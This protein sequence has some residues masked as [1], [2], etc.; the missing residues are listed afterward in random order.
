MRCRVFPAL[1]ALLCLLSACRAHEESSESSAKLTNTPS[2]IPA[3]PVKE[4]LAPAEE[5]VQYYITDPEDVS[6]YI[7]VSPTEL[8]DG[9]RCWIVD[10]EDGSHYIK[11]S[12]K[13]PNENGDYDYVV[14][15]GPELTQEKMDAVLTEIM[16]K[17]SAAAVSVAA[18]EDGEVTVSDAWGW[19]VKN[20][21]EMTAGTKVRV[22][23]LSK[24]VVGMSA[25]A[26]A[27]DE[28]LV[29]DAPLSDYWGESIRNPY[30]SVQP[31]AYTLMTHTSSIANRENQRGLANLRN[32]LRSSWR[33]MEP[34][35]GR[36]WNYNNFGFCILGT[37]LELAADQILDDYLQ[38]RFLEPMGIRASLYAGKL[39]EDEVACLYNASGGIAR[40]AAAQT[41]Q[42]VPADIG[43]GAS[44]YPGGLTISALDLAKLV[45]VLINDGVY[46]GVRYLSP[47]SVADMETPRFT[48]DLKDAGSF[49]QCL[50]LRH[51]K[52]LM[53]RSDLYYHTGSAYGVYALLSYDPDSRDG[54]V[55]ITVGAPRRVD[56]RGL[57]AL[58][59]E[60]SERLYAEMEGE[61]S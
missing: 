42:S 39:E 58:C 30:S 18:I 44:Y 4:E 57:Y 60:V 12:L 34:G 31:S 7:Q 8:G 45:S 22:A 2:A 37:T 14:W 9:S 26:M 54:V 49:E 43:Q 27:E 52:D 40:S 36:G 59:A 55:V 56:D 23:S 15:T 47:E 38:A 29:L 10:P 28:L 21:R 1:L 35:N 3:D 53:G 51:Q 17:Y 19:A 6:H 50:V 25:M 20:K 46:D 41:R 33:K 5:P 13:G 48:V 32:V 61:L 16:E 24:V 11:V